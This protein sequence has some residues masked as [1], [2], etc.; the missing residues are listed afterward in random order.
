MS[1]AHRVHHCS[2]NNSQPASGSVPGGSSICSRVFCT[3][4]HNQPQPPSAPC[5][6]DVARNVSL[7]VLPC[8]PRLPV[9]VGHH[10][11]AQLA[12]KLLQ[13][14]G[15]VPAEGM[16]C[17]RSKQLKDLVGGRGMALQPAQ[18]NGCRASAAPKPPPPPAPPTARTAAHAPQRWLHRAPVSAGCRPWPAAA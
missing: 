1:G 7:Q 17:T 5:R 13:R 16:G 15:S 12:V 2:A 3:P 18:R 4:P 9:G 8:R 11:L 6:V 10:H 14:L